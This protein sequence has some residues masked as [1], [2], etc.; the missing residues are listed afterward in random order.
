ME[1]LDMIQL[2]LKREAEISAFRERNAAR[3]P[4]VYFKK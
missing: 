3:R 1:G 4:W 2:T